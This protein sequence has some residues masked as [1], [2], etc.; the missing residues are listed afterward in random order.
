MEW[1]EYQ[2][3]LPLA[4]GIIKALFPEPKTHKEYCDQINQSG[5]IVKLLSKNQSKQTQSQ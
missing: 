1:N 4:K 3:M 5:E 2:K